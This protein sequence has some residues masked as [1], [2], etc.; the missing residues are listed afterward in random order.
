VRS[1]RELALPYVAAYWRQRY[2]QQAVRPAWL[3]PLPDP[4][5]PPAPPADLPLRALV[6]TLVASLAAV[7]LV[8]LAQARAEVLAGGLLP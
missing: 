4:P 6:A 8:A 2:G 7:L 3:A 1:A 5:A